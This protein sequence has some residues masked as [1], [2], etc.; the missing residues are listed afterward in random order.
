MR[1]AASDFRATAP[2][3]NHL[4]NDYE[5][6]N[7]RGTVCDDEGDQSY[8]SD[9]HLHRSPPH[10]L[11]QEERGRDEQ[12]SRNDNRDETAPQTNHEPC[13]RLLDKR[14]LAWVKPFLKI[15]EENYDAGIDRHCD[16]NQCPDI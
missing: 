1:D 6:T 11:R 15:P 7:R 2:F 8:L 9:V 16:C 10:M 5:E 14:A 4:P 12:I 3:A 13:T